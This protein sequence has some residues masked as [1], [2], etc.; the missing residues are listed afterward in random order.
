MLDSNL[1]KAIEQSKKGNSKKA[2]YFLAKVKRQTLTSKK[3][4]LQMLFTQGLYKAAS[5]EGT[6]IL[7]LSLGAKEFSEISFFVGVCFSKYGDATRA[8]SMLERCADNDDSIDNAAAIYNLICLYY[9]EGYF[10]KLKTK[11]KIL[12]KFANY[13]VK[14][15]VILMK[16]AAF[17]ANKMDLRHYCNYLY[18]YRSELDDENLV[19][20]TRFFIHLCD[21][22]K[23]N[24][25]L[26]EIKSGCS[27]N[28]GSLTAELM[29]TSGRTEALESYLLNILSKGGAQPYVYYQLGD[30]QHRNRYFADAFESYSKAAVLKL[31]QWK[32]E[33][34]TDDVDAWNKFA[35]KPK[36]SSSDGLK[37][38]RSMHNRK[39]VFIYGFP[40]SGTTLLDNI[41]DTQQDIA[42]LSELGLVSRLIKRAQQYV[43]VYPRDCNKLTTTQIQ[44]LRHYYFELVGNVFV[45]LS[46]ETVIVDKGP[47]HTKVLP[48]LR[49]IFPEA[50]FITAIR[51]PMDVCF[52]CFQQNFEFNVPNSFLTTLESTVCRYNEI[53]TLLE[54][55]ETTLNI[56]TYTVK[57]EELVS[58]FDKTLTNIFKYL[59][60]K[61]DDS[62]KQ[63]DKHASNKYITSSS[64]GQTDKALYNNSI[65]K[66]EKYAQQLKPYKE[67]LS[68]FIDKYGY[69]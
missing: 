63:F 4:K 46:D 40:R 20:L 33:A 28:V 53:F 15:A 25:L 7:T 59:E 3:L 36:C 9:Q 39:L 48:L 52:S 47:H 35:D 13:H 24:V 60:V 38:D 32:R 18:N 11:A 26:S 55:Y 58:D 65:Y 64:R 31:E 5:I 51:H 62:Y 6:E 16:V 69:D 1:T 30:L 42:V 44:L 17:L 56:D 22:D 37:F 54:K 49:Y 67:R 8:I 61:P 27:L 12:L 14:T 10:A 66:W 34:V 29:I 43:K 50:K 2:L 21:F 41:L 45:G 19:E 68:Y 23:A 57:Y